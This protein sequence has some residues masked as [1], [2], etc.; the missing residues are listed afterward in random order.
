MIA[1]I[2]SVFSPYYVRARKRGAG[3]PENHCALN[4]AL[5]GKGAAR[6]AMTERGR[7]ALGR[8]GDSLTI[9]P[10]ALAWDG[11]ALT[12]DIDEIAVPLPARLRG[13]VRISPLAV[14]GHVAVLDAA[15]RH[16][17]WPIAPCARVEVTMES[18]ALRWTGHGYLDSNHGAA[19]L[20]DSFDHWH[21]SRA[22]LPGGAAVL[23]DV[24]GGR[25]EGP[26]LA[27][28]FDE[29]GVAEPF[30][31]PPAAPLP[32]TRW[33]VRRAT[34]AD[35]GHSARVVQSLEDTPFYAR[36]VLSSRLLGEPV[37]AVHESLSLARF[38]RGWVRQLLPFR[39]PRAWR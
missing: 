5:Y 22:R 3:D 31:P 9:G 33:A 35:A 18:P 17:W 36:S 27:L 19:P 8:D 34:R 4:V 13:R 14:T 2:G 1:F 7:A 24:A 39:M 30:E 21:W 38:R 29:H 16:R 25:T 15:G 26:P 20:E 32:R 28:R 11:T 6:W 23:Y 10:S 12:V 37:I